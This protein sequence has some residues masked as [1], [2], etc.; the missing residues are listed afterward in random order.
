MSVGLRLIK[1]VLT[2]LAESILVPLGLTAASS[3]T[4]AAIKKKIYGLRTTTLVFSNEGLNDI[5]KMLNLLKN[6]VC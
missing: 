1:N 6:Q 4:D 2:P 5:T 3:A